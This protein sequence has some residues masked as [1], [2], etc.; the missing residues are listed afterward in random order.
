MFSSKMRIGAMT[1]AGVTLTLFGASL[2][3]GQTRVS[4]MAAA[5]SNYLL[6]PGLSVGQAAFNIATIGQ[7]LSHVPPAF[8]EP[9]LGRRLA[10]ASLANPYAAL[11]TEQAAANQYAA[12][13]VNPYAS[14]YAN[15]YASMVSNP[16]AASAGYDNSYNPYGYGY[17][18]PYDG[19]LRGAADV[20]GAQGRFL[21]S[22]QQAYQMREQVRAERVANRR[23]IFDEYLY[24]REKAPTAE[25]DRQKHMLEQLER[26]RNNPPITEVWSGKSLNDLLADLRKYPP[27]K[28]EAGNLVNIQQLPLDEEGLKHVNVTAGAGNGGNIGLL[29]NE[30]RLNW[31]VAMSEPQFKELR[32]RTNSL[33]QA[34]VRQAEFNGRV[35][36][37]TILQMSNDV[38]NLNR[39]LRQNSGDLPFGLY[40]EAKTF[41]NNLGAAITAL[42]QPDVGNYFTGKFALKAKTVP[43]LVEEMSKKGLQFAPATPGDEAAYAALQQAL[44]NYDMAVHAQMASRK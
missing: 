25:D 10:A 21:V 36:G 41:L 1:V 38:N 42:G 43:E 7:A 31:P 2:A 28:N 14:L 44:A 12:L 16:Y 37:G 29:K 15:P 11:A 22:T 30:G 18:D 9:F 4:P 20:I 3:D 32:E 39:L 27:S 13:A 23:R 33:A 8:R 40:I 19:Y 17:Y 35:D 6:R 24:E 5:R 26:S 34:A